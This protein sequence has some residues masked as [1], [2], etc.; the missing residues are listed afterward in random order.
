M[1]V[2]KYGVQVCNAMGK[3]KKGW[4]EGGERKGE[5]EGRGHLLVLVP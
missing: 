1:L 2:S 5:R 4:M 3:G